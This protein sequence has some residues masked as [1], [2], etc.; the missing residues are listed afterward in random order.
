MLHE[1]VCMRQKNFHTKTFVFTALDA[2]SAYS[3]GLYVYKYRIALTALGY[4][5]TS[6]EPAGKAV[7]HLSG[8]VIEAAITNI[9][10]ENKSS[11]CLSYKR[12]RI[13]YMDIDSLSLS[14]THHTHTHTHT[15]ARAR[16]HAHAQNDTDIQIYRHTD[17][18]ARDS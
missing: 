10:E 4:T 14:L 18:G 5:C 13:G 9:G 12:E 8:K 2:H 6:I 16:A 3:S 17:R 7:E 1:N 15:Y 11:K